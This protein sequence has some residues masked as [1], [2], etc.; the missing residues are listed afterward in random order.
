M[1]Y[2]MTLVRVGMPHNVSALGSV[3]DINLRFFG[4]NYGRSIDVPT[5]Y[6][7]RWL[8]ISDKW[9]AIYVP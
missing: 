9:F 2:T 6:Y 7:L 4:D 3:F 8:T 1:N 5:L